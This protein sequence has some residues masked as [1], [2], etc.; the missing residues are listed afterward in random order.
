MQRLGIVVPDQAV[1]QAVFAMPAFRGPNG[2]FDQQRFQAVLRN[3]GLTEARFLDMM[4][5]DLAQR[6]LLERGQR[7]RGAAGRC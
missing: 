3:N 4:R 2:Q 7:R 1:R 5:A 6:Q